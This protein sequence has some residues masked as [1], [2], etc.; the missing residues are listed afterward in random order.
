VTDQTYAAFVSA[1]LACLAFV[2]LFAAHAVI[3]SELPTAGGIVYPI[4][5]G[6]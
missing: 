1:L 3:D 6:P 5:A 4:H 2:I